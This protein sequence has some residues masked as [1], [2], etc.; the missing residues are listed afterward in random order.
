M[1][2]GF[3]WTIARKVGGLVAVLIGFI[4]VLL[5]HSIIALQEIQQDLQEIAAIDVPLTEIANEIEILQLEQHIALDELL[6]KINRGNHDIATEKKAI[7]SLTARLNSLFEDALQISSL[8]L[9]TPSS[10]S[11]S[12]IH[13]VLQELKT[14]HQKIDQAQLQLL[15][16]VTR[17]DANHATLIDSILKQDESFDVQAIQL[18]K[19]VEELTHRKTQVAIRHEEMFSVINTSLSVMGGLLGIIL[20]IVIVTGIKRNIGHINSKIELVNS[21]IKEGGAIP[22]EAI[23]ALN[24]SDELGA[25]SKDLSDLIA[26]VSDDINR[27]DLLSQELNDL[28]TLDHLTQCFNRFKWDQV[29]ES[30]LLRSKQ[31]GN[32]LSLIFFDIDHFKSINDTHGHD[33]GDT[34]LIDVVKVTQEA[35]RNLDTLYRTGGEEFAILLPDTAIDD[36]QALAERIRLAIAEYKFATVGQVTISLGVTQCTG[37]SDDDGVF[38]K[39][40][41][42]A[43]YQAKGSGRNRVCVV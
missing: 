40:A 41:D 21:A 39:R 42:E 24:S 2:Q 29:R 25:L 31:T 9:A 23:E 36:A 3:R 43:L 32:P 4:L 20:A 17:L 27:R 22:T 13:Q 34:T 18:I 33:V 30:E 6:R 8:G 28:A 5:V 26:N 19:A 14:K 12:A 10:D 38:A 16:E 15:D 1:A 11:F 7:K 35:I 37:E